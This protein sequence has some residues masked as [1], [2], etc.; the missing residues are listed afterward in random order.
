MIF[1]K[2]NGNKIS[3]SLFNLYEIGLKLVDKNID[4]NFIHNKDI[5]DL[6]LL[7]ERYISL[8]NNY[9]GNEVT[10]SDSVISNG[11]SVFYDKKFD[12]VYRYF[13]LCSYNL[14]QTMTE[15]IKKLSLDEFNKKMK[16]TVFINNSNLFKINKSFDQIEYRHGI[17]KELYKLED[18]NLKNKWY[19]IT[20]EYSEN[21]EDI[22]YIRIR[23]NILDNV[24]KKYEDLVIDKI[25]SYVPFFDYSGYVY[26]KY[27]DTFPRLPNEFMLFDKPVMIEDLSEGLR[28]MYDLD[29]SAIGKDLRDINPKI[30]LCELDF[31]K[32]TRKL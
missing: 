7:K 6:D 25:N 2:F 31:D 12:K 14:S 13:I 15:A 21:E 10:S 3:G 17:F 8:L 16:K 19:T 29:D 24:K 26:I 1:L 27:F 18:K 11:F 30:F 20:S 22:Q 23:K 5:V 9:N 4:V 28:K 32:I